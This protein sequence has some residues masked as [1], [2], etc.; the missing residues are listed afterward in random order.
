MLAIWS[1]C[2]TAAK[3]K[4][5]KK[6]KNKDKKK[7]FVFNQKN[8]FQFKH[9][10]KNKQCKLLRARRAKLIIAFAEKKTHVTLSVCL[11]VCNAP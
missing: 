7:P 8:F 11:Y 5:R 9:V 3:H 1:E 2:Q 10:C 4:K 6:I